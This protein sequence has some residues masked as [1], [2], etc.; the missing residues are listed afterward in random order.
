MKLKKNIHNFYYLCNY[1]P[2]RYI[3]Y[4]GKMTESIIQFKRGNH[5]I[6]YRF[7]DAIADC[8][9]DE[10]NRS[11]IDFNNT[12]IIIVPSHRIGE[13]NN[14]LI[15]LAKHISNRLNVNDF[16]RALVRTELHPKLS[17]G[18]TRTIESHFETIRFDYSNFSVLDKKVIL[19]DDITT[20]GNS[21]LACKRILRTAG[22][23]EVRCI[24]IAQ[25]ITGTLDPS[26]ERNG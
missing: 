11:E 19:F 3:E 10:K 6:A 14:S 23:R 4:Y 12:C 25:T 18:G 17:K 5:D 21:F 13:W 7:A 15:F 20:T 2:K 26:Y 24:A 1:Y 22:A 8:L 16:D 9:I